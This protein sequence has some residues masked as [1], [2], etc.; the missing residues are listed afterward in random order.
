MPVL[1]TALLEMGAAI[2]KAVVRLWLQDPAVASEGAIDIAE[3]LGR[4][5]PTVLV[6]RSAQR[7]FDR[8]AEQV[9]SNLEPHLR[10]EYGGLPD[11][12]KE[13]AIVAVAQTIDSTPISE[14]LLL[15]ADLDP[16]RIEQLFRAGDPA[17]KARALLNPAASQFYDHLL[18]E[19]CDYIVAINTALPRFAARSTAEVLRRE[20]ELLETTRTILANLP[21]SEVAFAPGTD[22]FEKRYRRE[23]VRRLDRLELF[24]ITVSDFSRRYRLSVAYISLT[25]TATATARKRLRTSDAEASENGDADRDSNRDRALEAEEDDDQLYLRA[26]AALADVGRCLIRGEAGSGKTTLLQYLAVRSGGQTFVDPLTP[27]NDT[28]PFFIQLRR[29]AKVDLPKPEQYLDNITPQLAGVMPAG[30]VHGQLNSGR[31]LVLVD[32]VDELPQGRRNDAE[33]WLGGLSSAF[34]LAKFVVTSRPPAIREDWLAPE[35]F[36]STELQ[37]M[38]VPDIAAFIEHWHDAAASDLVDDA[39]RTQ[40]DRLKAKLH[41]AVRESAPIRSLATSP[42]L[43]AMLCAL[44]RDRKSQLP[45]DRLE[46][47][48]IA[49]ETL[50]ER[51]DIEREVSAD[52][53]LELGLPVKEILLQDLAYWLMR[54]ARADI[55]KAAASNRIR[56]K[57]ASMPHVEESAGQVLSHLLERSGLLREPVEGRLDF[58]HRTFQEYLAAK[59]ATEADDIGFLINHAHDADWREV[60]ILAA[61]HARVK[62]RIQLISGLLQRGYAE[63]DNRHLLHLLAVACLE[64]SPELPAVLTDE[65]KA[66]LADLVP[67]TNMTEARALASAGEL[68]VPLLAEFRKRTVPIAT[69]CIRSLAL[70]GGDR[71]LEVLTGYSSD[72][73]ATVGRE[74]VRAWRNFHP[75]KYA[76]VVL[77][78]APFPRGL[79]IDDLELVP[80]VRHLKRLTDLTIDGLSSPSG[81]DHVDLRVLKQ[82][83]ASLERLALRFFHPE[84]LDCLQVLTK[85]SSVSIVGCSNVDSLEPIRRLKSLQ[86]VQL[87]GPMTVSNLNPLGNLPELRQVILQGLA[88]TQLGWRAGRA[89]QLISLTD[90]PGLTSLDGLE[91]ARN[92][93]TVLATECDRLSDISAL[94]GS[95]QLQ[96][97]SIAGA[98]KLSD[99]AVLGSKSSLIRLNLS[100]TDI[101][102]FGFLTALESLRQL[103]LRNAVNLRTLSVLPKSPDLYRIDLSLSAI[104]TLAGLERAPGLRDLMLNGCTELRD[105]AGLRRNKRLRAL[106]LLG[107]TG[108]TSLAPLRPL[109]GLQ[110]LDLEGCTG[111][112]DLSPLFGLRGLATVDIRG[113]RPGL[114]YAPLV[115]R[116]VRV[117]GRGSVSRIRPAPRLRRV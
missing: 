103:S 27:W 110:H 37:P 104:E 77:A 39:E 64:T 97:V 19:S 108:I 88:L 62:Q 101:A 113:C 13:A 28:V 89:L 25:A 54:N 4:K 38:A 72:D 29:Y 26:D 33:T 96:V 57:L 91:R 12:E 90:L 8:I 17:A 84:D 44:N 70:I 42:L 45:K 58:V 30:W 68:A 98:P 11:N 36:E 73:R 66:C 18:R 106:Y 21:Q 83:K 115:E 82:R 86:Y 31:A 102:E 22:E 111:I 5:I 107:A 67:P 94:R 15:S 112:E 95:K 16:F 50:V 35:G 65:L 52:E 51:R 53:N 100:G 78:N 63:P 114:D 23:I 55:E 49:L 60:I 75:D 14:D 47:Y 71:A 24:G 6:R 76:E 56:S 69:A 81:G 43:C 2:A 116:G 9:A 74:L 41:L 109:N 1:E 92:L 48:R 80:T 32:G 61:G 40:L 46:L 85:L 79:Q 10:V 59:A 3:V 93:V 99:A 7:T 20:S 87:A 105:L 34:P 117:V